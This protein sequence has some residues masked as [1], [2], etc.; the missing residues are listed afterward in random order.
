MGREAQDQSQQ[1]P[2]FTLGDIQEWIDS[3]QDRRVFEYPLSLLSGYTDALF[4]EGHVAMLS[5]CFKVYRLPKAIPTDDTSD[6]ESNDATTSSISKGKDPD[7]TSKKSVS[8]SIADAIRFLDKAQ[9]QSPGHTLHAIMTHLAKNGSSN[10][11]CHYS[12]LETLIGEEVDAGRIEAESRQIKF[13]KWRGGL[14]PQSET[15]TEEHMKVDLRGVCVCVCVFV[16]V[17]APIA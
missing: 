16:C 10:L 8:E 15:D 11:M 9:S 14:P 3:T 4:K 2:G 7:A 6:P 13:Y 17:C 5:R 1:A 12:M